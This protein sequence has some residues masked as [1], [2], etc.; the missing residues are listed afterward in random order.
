MEKYLKN[1][2]I[3]QKLRLAFGGIL[4]LL[5]MIIVSAVVSIT[6]IREQLTNFYNRPYVNNTL[7]MEIRKDIQYIGKQLLWATTT[8]SK[9][10]T[11]NH[12]NEASQYS[13]NIPAKINQLKETFSNPD[14]ISQ[15]E[16]TYSAMAQARAQI[17]DLAGNNQNTEALAVYNDE[18]DEQVLKIQDILIEIG[19]VANTVATSAYSTANRIG[20]I[21]TLF[22]VSLGIGSI[23]I[24]IYLGI[25]ITASM[26]KPIH[27]LETAAKK[28]S[29]G[30]L[31]VVIDYASQDEI[32]ILAANFKKACAFMQEIITDTAYLLG[33]LSLGNFCA[34]TEKEG[35]YL[36]E[37]RKILDSIRTTE[38]NLRDTLK[39]I[40]GG[41]NQ[42]S[43][44][45]EQMAQSAQSLASGATEQAGAIEELTAT[46]E[47]V[48]SMSK[49]TATS[50]KAAAEQTK[51]AVQD[52]QA[53]QASMTEL[54][55]AMENISEVSQEIQNIIGAIEDIASQTNLLSLNASIEAARAGEAGRGFAVVADQIG[56][57]ASDSAKSA[58]ETRDLIEK[59]LNEI[60]HGNVI[61]KQTV[62]ALEDIINS[63]KNFAAVA[64][65]SSETS[66]TQAELLAQIQSGI[67]QI[68]NVVQTNSAAAQ[69]SSA[70]SEELSAQ[71]E[72]LKALVD[73]FQL[74]I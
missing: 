22:M 4:L 61:T 6:I 3:G 10:E 35:E 43:I 17:V 40:D 63:I 44:G 67:E 28:L 55:N 32:G 18:Y 33:E 57:L 15:L 12:L 9:E 50:A 25:K 69:E 7:Q 30:E 46:V 60:E 20:T 42:V 59:S 8:D 41:A 52:A 5:I 49:D 39:E 72:N 56:K 47:N 53:G 62:T 16:E 65:E 19:N 68:A 73:Q 48:A 13:E 29:M 27:Q 14:L 36:G 24:G 74:E 34:D 21:A 31:D 45:A 37:F 26:K 58:V 38:A 54:V 66:D 70:T 11:Q 51:L 71:S 1:K 23:L 2:K 64:K